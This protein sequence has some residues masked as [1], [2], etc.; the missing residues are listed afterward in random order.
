M[1]VSSSLS[2]QTFTCDGSTTVFTCPFRVLDASELVG[3]LVTVATNESVALV[4]G[5]DFAVT[6]VGAAN[7]IATTTLAYS[8]TYQVNFRR[9]TL[10]LQSTDYRDND[11]FPAESHENALDRLTHIAQENDTDIGRALLAPEPETGITLPSAASRANLL[12][13]FNSSGAPVAVA[14]VGGSA[15]ALALDLANSTTPTKGAGQVAF[16]PTLNYALST[17]GWAVQDNHVNVFWFLSAAERADVIG[18]TWAI[19]ITAK[20]AAAIAWC[21]QLSGAS[22]RTLFFPRGLYKASIDLTNGSGVCIEGDGTKHTVIKPAITSGYALNAPITLFNQTISKLTLDGSGSS[23]T[24]A[25]IY[26]GQGN[27]TV[28][29]QVNVSGWTATSAAA[30]KIEAACY[31]L[32]FSAC[33]F[34]NNFRHW[35]I[36]RTVPTG[37]FPTQIVFDLCIFEEATATTGAAMSITDCSGIKLRDC[38]VQANAC[39]YTLLVAAT[40]AAETNEDPEIHGGWWEDNGG[41]QVGSIAIYFFGSASRTLLN[42]SVRDVKFHQ[43]SLNKPAQQIR[44]EYTD[45]F[46]TDGCT[47]GYGAGAV[48]LKN[49]GN[50]TNYLT[51]LS[52]ITSASEL[53][54]PTIWA[55]GQFGGKT[56]VTVN[57]SRNCTITR[58]SAGTYTIT[59]IKAAPFTNYLVTATAEDGSVS[60]AMV[61]S[62]GI[63]SSTASFTITTT[64]SD[65]STATDARNVQFIVTVQK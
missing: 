19:D 44:C 1:T 57:Q 4:N 28:F 39:I 58:A 51:D 15:A 41:G 3:Y 56:T 55:S 49:G 7:A 38:T 22:S 42:P 36:S 5:T 46:Q 50:N 60:T 16:D 47:E 21:Y 18:R 26:S 45:G 32:V 61:A 59:F 34:S 52:R 48:F 9:R 54:S 63:P 29:S 43:S 33:H 31:G 27:R 6:G 13:G 64:P 35:T 8:N 20:V 53:M 40:A 10:R 62:P 12:L 65:S 14:P 37:Q 2:T 25:A 30:M 11:P 24:A 23:G 17:I